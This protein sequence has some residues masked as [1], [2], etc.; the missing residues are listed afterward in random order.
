MKY[1]QKC[2]AEVDNDAVICVKCGCYTQQVNQVAEVDDT[3]SVGLVILAVLIPL[4]GVIYWIIKVKSRP[5]CA[6]SCAIAGIISWLIY[7]L[8]M[9]L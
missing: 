7:F 4:F 2:G 3:V 8:A 9:P 5:R 6:V 1:C